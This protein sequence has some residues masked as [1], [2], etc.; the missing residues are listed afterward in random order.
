MGFL[1]FWGDRRKSLNQKLAKMIRQNLFPSEKLKL[2][3]KYG[4]VSRGQF[5][6][7]NTRHI[8][9]QVYSLGKTYPQYH[10]VKDCPKQVYKA[11]KEKVNE[12]RHA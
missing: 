1:T 5:M 2:L 3:S 7:A 9:D 6:R 12:H 8:M 10:L 11:A 4:R